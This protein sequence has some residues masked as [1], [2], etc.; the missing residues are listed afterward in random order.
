MNTGKWEFE[1]DKETD[2]YVLVLDDENNPVST[3]RFLI[4]ENNYGL[5]E[6]VR[7]HPMSRKKGYGKEAMLNVEEWLY[8]LGVKKIF[9]EAIP[10]ALDFYKKLG[11]ELSSD[12]EVLR[13][14][15]DLLLMEKDL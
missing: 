6:R 4:D 8:D 13:N 2:R 11:Y 9:V 14:H 15:N 1:N 10:P 3:A 12:S 5:V 7:T